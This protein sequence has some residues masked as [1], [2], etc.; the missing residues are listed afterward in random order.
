MRTTAGAESSTPSGPVA[1]TPDPSATPESALDPSADSVPLLQYTVQPGDTLTAVARR[2]YGDTGALDRIVRT[3]LDQPMPDGRVFAD[4]NHIRPGWVLSLPQPAQVAYERDGQ[5]WYVVQP[6]DTLSSIAARLLGSANRWHELY[7][8][9]SDHIAAP[10]RIRVGAKL[11]LPVS[12][13]GIE[14][15][16]AGQDDEAV[17]VDRPQADATTRQL[18]TVAAAPTSAPGSRIA[19]PTWASSRSANLDAAVMGDAT[20][21]DPPAAGGAQRAVETPSVAD[22]GPH[23]P[24]ELRPDRVTPSGSP[25]SQGMLPSPRSARQPLAAAAATDA[26]LLSG[27]TLGVWLFRVG[28]ARVSNLGPRSWPSVRLLSLVPLRR[29]A[30]SRGP[31]FPHP[32]TP[33]DAPADERACCSRC[34]TA[35]ARTRM[36]RRSSRYRR[37]SC[38]ACWPPTETVVWTRCGMPTPGASPGMPCPML[39]GIRSSS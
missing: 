30:V 14:T 21:A 1:I 28:R 34:W 35:P 11:Q 37:D 22:T 2:F 13:P 4:A 20:P 29:P 26:M 38:V 33:T 17:Q 10:S 15:A 27:I 6:G 32:P 16:Q 12:Q 24:S 19:P 39:S 5:R 9:N 8:L 25:E 23:L 3:N 7:A 36:P 18:E 31:I